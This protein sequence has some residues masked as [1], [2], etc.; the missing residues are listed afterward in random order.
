MVAATLALIL[1]IWISV[2]IRAAFPDDDGRFLVRVYFWTL[3]LRYCGALWLNAYSGDSTFADAYW[4]DSG[5]Y[6]MGGYLV[7]Q[8]WAG[9]SFS[10]PTQALVSGYGFMYFVGLIYYVVGRNQ[11]FV[12]FV[13]G[14]IGSLA[15][16]VIYAI[17]RHLFDARAARWAALFMAFFPQMIFWSCAMYKDPSILLCIA[18]SMYSVLRLRERLTPGY[19][20]LFMA[21]CL[22][23]MSLRFY[24]FYMVAFATLGTFLFAQRR[25]LFSGLLAQIVL[26]GAFVAS[27]IFVVRGETI[28]Q[29]SSY[30]DLEKLQT[31]RAGQATLGKSA[32]GSDI[33]VS[34]TEGALAA[35]PV[36]LLY[37]LFAPFPWAISGIRQ[38]MTLPE[39]LVWYALMPALVRGLLHTI[40]HR[41]RDS[42]P[43]LVFAVTLTVAYA[44]F[45]SNVGTAYRQRTQ[46]TMFFFIFMGAGIELKKKRAK[47]ASARAPEVPAWQR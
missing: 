32:F 26:V 43:I 47:Q 28:E 24:V 14:T 33:N 6:D 8:R 31:A 29:Q 42:L 17:A 40:R 9:E 12:Q 1:N 19:I 37:L 15:V 7:A 4:G 39:T 22:Y 41:L 30:F 11:L 3:A 20:L 46:V 5:T 16:I 25:G 18:V 45:Q 44:I 21:S 27:M 35:L 36:G 23:L 10:L 13:N 38:L 34:T 2:R